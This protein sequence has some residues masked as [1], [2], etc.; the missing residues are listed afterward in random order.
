[1]G[2]I[3]QQLPIKQLALAKAIAKCQQAFEVSSD[4]NTALTVF[5]S[6]SFDLFLL[7]FRILSCL[8]ALMQPGKLLFC[9]WMSN[10]ARLVV[11]GRLI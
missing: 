3:P 10:L 9:P 11:G 7:N 4:G 6:T 1:M 8:S 2:V 5:R